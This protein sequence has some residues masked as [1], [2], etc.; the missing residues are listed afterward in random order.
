[1]Y[2]CMYVPHYVT[3]YLSLRLPALYLSFFLTGLS[4]TAIPPSTRL[5]QSRI[6]IGVSTKSL[7][8]LPVRFS[9]NTSLSL[10]P[11]PPDLQL[12]LECAD[13]AEAKSEVRSKSSDVHENLGSGSPSQEFLQSARH[14]IR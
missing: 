7:L 1:M 12:K 3:N 6:G 2:L 4:P 10:F 9:K 13:A 5:A 14:G 8:P 11:Q